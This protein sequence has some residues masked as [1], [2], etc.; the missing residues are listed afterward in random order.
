M[1]HKDL[2]KIAHNWVLKNASCG[3]AFKEL[4]TITSEIPDVIGFGSWTH[5]VIVE[6]K[7]SRSDVLADKNKPFRKDPKTG[8]GTHR[9]Y[10]CPKGL[11]KKEELPYGWGLI[12]VS[13]KGKA[14]LFHKPLETLTSAG[15]IEYK[16]L[17]KHPKNIEAEHCLLYS[18]LRRLHLRGRIEEI[19]EVL[20]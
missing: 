12:Y 3:I 1:N 15:G 10:I 13:D 2:V 4:K 7:A 19:Y 6:C 8:M 18:A 11:I 20:K 14:T 16:R 17:I 5:S 9:Y